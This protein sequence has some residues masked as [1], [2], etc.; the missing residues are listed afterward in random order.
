MTCLFWCEYVLFN[1]AASSLNISIAS[2]KLTSIIFLQSMTL[3]IFF[4][5]CL[6]PVK[7]NSSIIFGFNVLRIFRIYRESSLSL[8]SDDSTSIVWSIKLDDLQD[9]H[10]SSIHSAL[11][12]LSWTFQ[13]GNVGCLR[14]I[15]CLFVYSVLSQEMSFHKFH[16]D[17][18]HAVYQRFK[19]TLCETWGNLIVV[20]LFFWWILIQ[21]TH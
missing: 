8:A 1:D 15:F 5:I 2:L 12:E 16:I 6:P 11:P 7:R 17:K 9:M 18:I 13:L 14:V 4:V 10:F 20:R 3:F 19:R 21:M